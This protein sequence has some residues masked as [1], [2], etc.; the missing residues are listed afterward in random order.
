MKQNDFQKSRARYK[1]HPILWGWSLLCL[2]TLPS[3]FAFADSP[4][5][6]EKEEASQEQNEAS[7]WQDKFRYGGAVWQ[8]TALRFGSNP[9]VSMV[10]QFAK[11][12][13]KFL[14]NETVHLKI[15]GR[16]W[17]DAVYDL[18]DQYP[19]QVNDNMRKEIILRDA[20][21]DLFAPKLNFRLGHQQVVWGESLGQ[22]FADVVNPRDL[23]YFLLP[24]F[25]YIRSMIWALDI[26][27]FFLPN[28]TWEIVATPDQN[29]DKLAPQ[30]ADFAFRLPNPPPGVDQVLLPD[31]RPDTN[32]K[33]WN[34]G[35]RITY[36]VKGWDFSWLYFT[37]LD[38]QP[39]LFKELGQNPTDGTPILFLE[40][41]HQRIHQYGFTFS[42]GVKSSILRGEFVYTQGRFFNAQDV[43]Q[44]QGVVRRNLLRYFLGFDTTLGG[45]VDMVTEFQQQAVFGGSNN[46]A[47]PTVQTWVLLH[48]ETGFFDEKLVPE[49]TFIVGLHEGDTY[50]GPKIHYYVKPSLRLTWGADIFTGPPQT[51]YGQFSDSSRAYM[52]TEW[53]F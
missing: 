19:P 4:E 5:V 9:N 33:N 53:T 10:K 39:V 16:A 32:F 1:I 41:Q 24:S 31:Q 28:A 22:F 30:G 20:Y 8:K 50:I 44:N 23:R 48:F 29:V 46:L 13:F 21:L 38:H 12:H 7:F 45:K 42:K 11:V 2:L 17:Y 43:T 18:T 49:I 27:Y 40:P 26:R 35:T 37:S 47:D 15:G 6:T 3:F 25:D 14:F 52:T 51:F 34:F 36:L